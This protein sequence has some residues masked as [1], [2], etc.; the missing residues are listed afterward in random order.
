[1]IEGVVTIALLLGSAASAAPAAASGE[2]GATNTV[3]LELFTSQGCSTCPPA[4]QLLSALGASAQ[5]RGRVVPLAFHVDYWNAGGWFDPF[6][7]RAWTLRQE[8]YTRAL[9]VEAPYTPQLIVDG[10]AELPG[11][12]QARV[13]EELNAALGRAPAARLTLA[14]RQGEPGSE[15]ATLTVNVAAELLEGVPE[16]KLQAVVALFENGLKTAVERG[17]NRGRSL[18]N[19]Y[20]VRRLTTAFSLEP[21]SETRKE[22]SVVFKLERAWAPEHLGVAAFLQDPGTMRIYGAAAL[23][24]LE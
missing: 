15:R 12:N 8:A 11:G 17:E 9:H 6:S 7:A 24:S 2:P 10:R 13:L 23:A 5:A 21:K 1:M 18:D 20:A 3:L 14:V 19:P 4:E 22:G 16:H